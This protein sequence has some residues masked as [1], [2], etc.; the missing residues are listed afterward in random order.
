M[1]K[2]IAIVLISMTLP[3][4]TTTSQQT[5]ADSETAQQL[6]HEGPSGGLARLYF[7][8]G[9][10]I[11][12]TFDGFSKV[13]FRADEFID[14]INVGGLNG[15]D[16]LVVDIP[17]GRHDLVW[18]ERSSSS[19]SSKP[20]TV[21]LQTG[22]RVYVSND[23]RMQAVP[24]P[25]LIFGA[26]GGAVAAIVVASQDDGSTGPLMTVRSNGEEMSSGNAVVLPDAGAVA[27]L[28]SQTQQ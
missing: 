16:I 1:N 24:S 6:L 27:R 3:S 13:S 19:P 17:A 20:L 25:L 14:G 11:N 7:F 10:L 4:C 15:H 5:F 8:D 21:M 18:R 2:Y 22:Q 12:G 28:R 9:R 26:I 23:Y